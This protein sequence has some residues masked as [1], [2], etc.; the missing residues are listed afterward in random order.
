MWK[1]LLLR[2]VVLGN[3]DKIRQR[4]NQNSWVET[5]LSPLGIKTG[6]EFLGGLLRNV[7][8]TKA[9]DIKSLIAPIQ[10]SIA[11]DRLQK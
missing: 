6:T 4:L 1:R 7:G 10:A 5:I 9:L 8:G 3:I 11:F 2:V